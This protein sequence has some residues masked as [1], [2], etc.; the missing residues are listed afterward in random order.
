MI[1][2]LVALALAALLLWM[3]AA[4]AEWAK[5]QRED[6]MGDCTDSCR[7]NPKVHPTRRAECGAY[8]ACVMSEGEKFV[9]SADY[10]TLEALSKAE[11]TSPLLKRFQTLYPICQRRVFGN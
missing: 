11:K 3:P 9:T 8:C 2:R 5:N 1:A 10:D 7:E 4:S 6:F